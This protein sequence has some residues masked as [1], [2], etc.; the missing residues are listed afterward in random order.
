MSTPGALRVVGVNGPALERL[1][2]LLAAGRLVQCVRVDHDLQRKS[3]DVIVWSQHA[4]S[5]SVS[6]WI[7]ICNVSHVMSIMTGGMHHHV[8]DGTL[9][10]IYRNTYFE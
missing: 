9:L 7:M 4:D 5:F 10:F 2:C 1:D 6:V 8:S 3:R